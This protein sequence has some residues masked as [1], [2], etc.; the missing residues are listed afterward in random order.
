MYE[1]L[2]TRLDGLWEANGIPNSIRTLYGYQQELAAI[3]ASYE[4]Y[5]GPPTP[6][7]EDVAIYSYMNGLYNAG[8]PGAVAD[9][10]DMIDDISAIASWDVDHAELLATEE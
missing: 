1:N 8:V 2:G 6:S 4:N 9:I 10:F 7:D 3:K 5:P